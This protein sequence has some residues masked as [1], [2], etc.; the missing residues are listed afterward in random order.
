MGRSAIVIALVVGLGAGI[1]VDRMAFPPEAT[2]VQVPAPEATAPEAPPPTPQAADKVRWKMASAFA[3]SAELLGTLAANLIGN[4][5]SISEGQIQLKFF[6]PGA[7]V[8]ALEIFD[9]VASGAVDTGWATPGFWAG[10]VPAL[11]LFAAVPFG[12]AAPEYM[13]WMYYGGGQELY[14]ELY[15]RH[16]I[17][18]ILCGIFPPE[19]SGWFRTE[20]TSLEDLKGLKMRFFALGAKVMEKLGVSTQLLAGGDIFPA[21][22]L[23]TIDAAEY[24]SPVIDKD[25]GF[26]QI[27]KHYYFP[28]WHQQS[29]WLDL[30]INLDRWNS[31][32]PVR[33]SQFRL[34]C[35][36]SVRRSI[37]RGEALQVPAMEFL[38]DKGV[39]FHKW[40]PEFLDAYAAAWVEVVAEEAAKDQDFAAA[41]ESLSQFRASYATWKDLGYLQ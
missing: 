40:R 6:E 13:A 7:L 14:D 36:D 26:Y 1:V 29:T 9:A 34:A 31:L 24:A 19:A 2:V 16:N 8:P 35:G 33:Q 12:P 18:G 23:G 22:E 4:L 15:A 17:K 21:L 5:D 37:A 27:A 11:Q 25:L 28:G 41:W 10:K 20:I 39:Q 3:G 30:T 38:A 32:S